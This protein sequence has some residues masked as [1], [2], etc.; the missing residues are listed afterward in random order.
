MGGFFKHGYLLSRLQ[1]GDL[2]AVVVVSREKWRVEWEQVLIGLGGRVGWWGVGIG[3]T[4]PLGTSMNLCC[5]I[6]PSGGLCGN[7]NSWSLLRCSLRTMAG[8]GVV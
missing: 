2:L 3:G 5:R 1:Q 4:P 8:L 6:L 7:P